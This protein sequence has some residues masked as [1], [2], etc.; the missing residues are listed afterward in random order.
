MLRGH[1]LLLAIGWAGVLHALPNPQIRGTIN[2]RL[3][4]TSDEAFYPTENGLNM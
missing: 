1:L 3:P 4:Y 2:K